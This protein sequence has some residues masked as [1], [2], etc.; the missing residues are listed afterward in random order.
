MRFGGV[1]GTRRSWRTLQQDERDI[2]FTET[3]K[4]KQSNNKQLIYIYMSQN[5]NSTLAA[6]KK[7]KKKKKAPRGRTDSVQTLKER[8]TGTGCFNSFQYLFS[9]PS[10]SSSTLSSSEWRNNIGSEVFCH[11][12]DCSRQPISPRQEARV[13]FSLGRFLGSVTLMCC[14]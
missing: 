13:S 7:K 4:P 3:S 11:V 2:R 5:V 9:L 8:K 10:Q 1:R 6:K 12:F 14:D